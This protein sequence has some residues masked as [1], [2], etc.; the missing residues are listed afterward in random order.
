MER[1]KFIK[2]CCYSAVTLSFTGGILQACGSI[3]Y[4]TNTSS[5]NKLSIAKTEFW[6]V[7]KNKKVE[8]K[9]ILTKTASSD[10]PICIYKTDKENYTASLLKCTHRGCELNVGGGVYTCPCHG[11]E[12]ST[13]GKVLEG[14]AEQNLKTFKV[15]TDNETIYVHLA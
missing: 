9:F 15:T 12:F 4:A 7:Q 14:P 3:Y 8:R 11:S 13:T 10:F 5:N 1:R 6:N 2:N